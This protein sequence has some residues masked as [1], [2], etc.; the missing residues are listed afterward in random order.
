MSVEIFARLH[1]ALVLSALH[2]QTLTFTHRRHG[3][4]LPSITPS[5]HT[6]KQN[7]NFA[8]ID[9]RAVRVAVPP[10]WRPKHQRKP[11][12]AVTAACWTLLTI[13]RATPTGRA[14]QSA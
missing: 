3:T 6:S 11:S 10:R 12:A 5:A 8:L 14:Q 2:Q 4:D 9:E 7:D 1:L 13:Y